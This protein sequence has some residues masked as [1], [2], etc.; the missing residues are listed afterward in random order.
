MRKPLTVL[1]FGGGQDSTTML[2][3]MNYIMSK[4]FLKK[5]NWDG[6]GYR[7]YTQSNLTVLKLT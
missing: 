6:T 4:L 5:T 2:L 3:R 7:L 1:W